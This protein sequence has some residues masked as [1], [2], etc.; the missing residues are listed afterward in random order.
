MQF[1]GNKDVIKTICLISKELEQNI[2]C[3]NSNNFLL[4]ISVYLN[5]TILLHRCVIGTIPGSILLSSL[6][7]ACG[8]V[9]FAYY[10]N[11]GCDPLEAGYIENPNQVC[12]DRSG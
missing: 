11:L 2:T 12:G 7:C 10:A 4:S 9:V 1:I 3:A 6:S 8:F 5:F